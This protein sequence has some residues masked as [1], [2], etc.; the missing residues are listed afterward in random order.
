MSRL[1]RLVQTCGS[2]CVSSQSR[3][4]GRAA[5]YTVEYEMDAAARYQRRLLY[6]RL[7]RTSVSTA[8]KL[9]LGR[10]PTAPTGLLMPT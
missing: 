10:L 7:R 4:T 3:G 1:V 5:N 6:E 2:F 8:V 9:S